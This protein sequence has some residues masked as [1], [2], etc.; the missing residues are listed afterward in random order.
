MLNIGCQHIMQNTSPDSKVRQ[1]MTVKQFLVQWAI[2]IKNLNVN[3]ARR[4]QG[5]I[6]RNLL[7]LPT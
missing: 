7:G 3:R 6:E 4:L 5:W 1:K 2:N